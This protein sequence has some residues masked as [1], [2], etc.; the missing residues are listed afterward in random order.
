[1]NAEWLRPR[2]RPTLALLALVAIVAVGLLAWRMGARLEE[3]SAFGYPGV[4][5]LMVLSGSS[6][7]PVPGPPAVVVAGAVWHPLLVGLAAGLGNASGEM[8]SY[9]LGG[10]AS[11]TLQSYRNLRFVALLE[12]WLSR[13]G[14]LAVL[15]LATIPNPTF[16]ALTL[17][18]GSLRYPPRR[19]WLACAIGN[20]LKYT[21]MA[22]LG[23]TALWLLG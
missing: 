23:H 17:L 5:L 9:V 7:F 14:F 18:A 2:A 13:H 4:F 11:G 15:A 6:Y 22:Y 12:G 20:T 3:L 8:T 16:H 21:A 19:Y 10:A 1:M